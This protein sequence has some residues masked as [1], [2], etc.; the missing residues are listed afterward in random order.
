MPCPKFD[1]SIRQQKLDKKNTYIYIYIYISSRKKKKQR[2]SQSSTGEL[3][4]LWK[5]CATFCWL[6]KRAIQAEVDENNT[7]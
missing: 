4:K 2:Y 7:N 6:Q 1:T 3:K 5:T